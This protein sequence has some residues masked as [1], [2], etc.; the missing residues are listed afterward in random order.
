MEATLDRLKIGILG[1]S[2]IAGTAFLAATLAKALSDQ[3][4]SPAVLELGRG[5]LFDS[6]GMDKLF[7]GGDFFYFHNAVANDR[8]IRGR[9]NELGGINWALIPSEE[10]S[11]N[12]DLYKKI[13][14]LNNLV[15]DVIIS[16]M[17]GLKGEELWKLTW[18]M[19]KIIVVIDPLPSKMLEGYELLCELKLSELPLIYVV[20]K[21]NKGVNRRQL[22]SYL[23]LKN[24]KY[25]PMIDYKAIYGAEYTCRTPYDIPEVK[26]VLMRPLSELI[27]EII[28]M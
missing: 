3:G 23:K 2:Q 21:Y 24:L 18:E 5:G 9:R 8:S 6:L 1:L 13:R 28:G 19:D 17:A 14:L 10:S 15:G 7:V 26:K 4:Y 25:I 12:L 16:R 27:N 20:N 11:T 22:L